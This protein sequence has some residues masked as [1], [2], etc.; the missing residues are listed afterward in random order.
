MPQARPKYLNLMQI[1]LP[2]PGLVSILHRVSGAALFLFI[3]FLLVLFELSLQSPQT[4]AHFKLVFSYWPVKLIMIG[5]LWAYLHHLC[6][7]IRHLALDLHYGTDLPAARATSWV[8][9]VISIGL[10]VAIAV[11]VW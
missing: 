11:T 7:G 5:L 9:L 10:T 8:V 4:F 1:R 2:L 3:P 6:A